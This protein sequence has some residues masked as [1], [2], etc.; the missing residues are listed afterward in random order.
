MADSVQIRRAEMRDAAILATFNSALAL[1]TENKSLDAKT[2][3][4][5]VSRLLADSHHGFYIVAEVDGQIA[6]CLMITYEWSDWR[7]GVFWW[8]QSV[9]VKPEF[10]RRGIY[11]ALYDYI[12]E[13]AKA[14]C[15]ICGLRLY[16]ENENVTAHRAYEKL[17]MTEA[18]YKIYEEIFRGS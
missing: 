12:R 17:G 5:G 15:D 10:R 18:H 3:R 11:R 4:A 2:I 1:E 8:I 9:Y 14:D 16:A 7:N 13:Q 6:G